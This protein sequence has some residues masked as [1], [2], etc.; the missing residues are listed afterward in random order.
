M[1]ASGV[2]TNG[3]DSVTIDGCTGEAFSYVDAAGAEQTLPGGL[4]R[5]AVA[6][7]SD[8]REW[9]A[10]QTER[11]RIE[12]Q[13]EFVADADSSF[14]E[15]DFLR[16]LRAVGLPDAVRVDV[17]PVIGLRPDRQTGQYHRLIS[18]LGAAA[19]ST[20]RLRID[21][22]QHGPPSLPGAEQ[23]QRLRQHER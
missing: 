12:L 23:E 1:A 2:A 13:L 6:M 3:G 4:F 22:P 19:A 18:Q 10:I 21:E 15:V 8:V 20:A 7:L 11:N 5:N 16:R 17:E 9:R 14:D